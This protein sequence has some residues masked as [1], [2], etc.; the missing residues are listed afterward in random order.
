MLPKEI[1]ID[2]KDRY[3]VL[4]SPDIKLYR[5]YFDELVRL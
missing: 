3:G 4:L 1:Q 5:N 2:D